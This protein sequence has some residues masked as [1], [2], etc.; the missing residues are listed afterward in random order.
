MRKKCGHYF[1]LIVLF[2]LISNYHLHYFDLFHLFNWLLNISLVSKLCIALV[3]F[4]RHIYTSNYWSHWMMNSINCV[5]IWSMLTMLTI[6][7]QKNPTLIT[8]WLLIHDYELLKTYL[9]FI[10]VMLN[11]FTT[12]PSNKIIYSAILY[13]QIC[14]IQTIKISTMTIMVFWSFKC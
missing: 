1:N 12:Y 8:Y 10:F 11:W 3:E 2:W 4:S 7:L 5:Q 9:E 13:K 14:Q 6:F